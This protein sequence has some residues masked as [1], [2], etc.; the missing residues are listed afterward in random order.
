MS[1][2]RRNVGIA[3]GGD[4]ALVPEM[5]QHT[6]T[7]VKGDRGFRYIADGEQVPRPRAMMAL[8]SALEALWKG[9]GA[10]SWRSASLK[11]PAW[12]RFAMRLIWR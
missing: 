6:R 11:S 3:L 5:I 12:M 1:P 7:A 9:S 2:Y 4:R 10:L 8:A